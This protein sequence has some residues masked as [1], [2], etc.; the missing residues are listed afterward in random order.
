MKQA[1]YIECYTKKYNSFPVE[2]FKNPLDR[3]V[4]S[5]TAM[6]PIHNSLSSIQRNNSLINSS[7]IVQARNQNNI[8]SNDIIQV[9]SYSNDDPSISND[10]TEKDF[11]K[12]M[13]LPTF[14]NNDLNSLRAL[15]PL[16][17]EVRKIM[18]SLGIS[19]ESLE[20]SIEQG[21]RSEIIGIYRIIIMRL[22]TQKEL[23][24]MSPPTPV[25]ND[26]LNNNHHSQKLP[27]TKKH[28]AKCAIL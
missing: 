7:R 15:N 22:K 14:T 3:D 4:S 20:K 2:K 18:K 24:L 6:I 5:N 17:V 12:F 25:I 26:M 8:R 13:M 1:E 9:R 10:D 11:E 21:P 16:E 27:K 19:D 28:N 23:S